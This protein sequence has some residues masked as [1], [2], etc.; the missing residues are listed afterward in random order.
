METLYY[1]I[2]LCIV[3]VLLVLYKVIFKFSNDDLPPGN[4]GWPIIGETIE[5]LFCTPE[6][7]VLKRMKK[8]SPDI[9][10]TNLFGEKMIVICG[11]K[12]LKFLFSNEQKPIGRKAQ[13]KTYHVTKILTLT[14]ASQIFLGIDEP[15]RIAR[16]LENFDKVTV[17]MHSMVVNF[18][19]T[20]FSKAT[21]AASILRREL[22]GVIQEKKEAISRGGPMNDVLSH[23]IVA[24]DPS[25][26]YMSEAEIADKV[27]GLLVAGYHTVATTMAFFIKL[28]VQQKEIWE[29]KKAGELL[30]WDDIKKM[31]Y[32][33]NVVYEVMRFTPPIQGGFREV[34]TDFTYAGFTVPKGWKLYWTVSTTSKNPQYYPEPEKFEP[35]RYEDASSC[36]AFAFVPFG[37]GPRMCPGKEYTRLAVLTFIHNVVKKFEWELII[38]NEKIEGDM[39]PYP[40]KGLPI[41]L[42]S[43]SILM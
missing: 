20:R 10:K 27:M 30:E 32:S 8:Y 11:P 14:L 31:K 22:N 16:L 29:S 21:K 25:G 17:G 12:G 43:N 34:L 26:K 3:P 24:T 28:N 6:N 9:F 40:Q 36:P 19:G 39:M 38:P 37:G 41:R 1:L 7:F 15:E 4:M 23:M 2:I 18:P 42:R 33:W 13:V 5:F 35:S